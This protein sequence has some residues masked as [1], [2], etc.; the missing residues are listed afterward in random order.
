MPLPLGTL[1]LRYGAVAL[2]SYVIA[3]QMPRARRDQRAED[4]LDAVDE[5]AAWR[6]DNEGVSVAAKMVRVLR[7]LG[8]RAHSAGVRATG[9]RVEGAI[10]ARL[11]VTRT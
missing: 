10:L 5:G 2:A 7:P 9:F 8:G 11:R 3:R 6:H 1:V 4:A